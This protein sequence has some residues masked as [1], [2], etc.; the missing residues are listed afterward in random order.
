[1]NLVILPAFIRLIWVH[2]YNGFKVVACFCLGHVAEAAEQGF[3]VYE[4]RNL[5]PKYVLSV[6]VERHSTT[7]GTQSPAQSIHLVLSLPRPDRL[8]SQGSAS[9][10]SAA[11]I[12]GPGGEEHYLHQEVCF[13]P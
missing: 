12:Y 5:H 2:R 7:N 6:T 4:T 9:S 13:A 10:R 8:R 3:F 11:K 1:M